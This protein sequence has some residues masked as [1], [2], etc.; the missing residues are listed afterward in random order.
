MKKRIYVIPLMILTLALLL[1]G[2]S[3]AT[4]TAVNTWGGAAVA[5]SMVYYA[6]GPQVL[7]LA[8]SGCQLHCPLDLSGKSS[9]FTPIY[10]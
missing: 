1:T 6:S 5:D 8:D 2:C 9:G 4:G 7:A 3:S 10:G